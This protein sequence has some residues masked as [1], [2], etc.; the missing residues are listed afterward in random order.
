M[1]LMTLGIIVLVAMMVTLVLARIFLK[2]FFRVLSII[3]LVLFVAGAVFGLLVYADAMEMKEKM[4]SMPSIFLLEKDGSLRAGF[5]AMGEK[6]ELLE[7]P[8]DFQDAYSAK[9]YSLIVGDKYYKAFMFRFEAFNSTPEIKINEEISIPMSVVSKAFSSESPSGEINGYL[10]GQGNEEVDFSEFESSAEAKGV[11]FSILVTGLTAENPVF[12][13]KGIKDKNII[14]YEETITFK[15][16][17]YFPSF[18]FDKAMKIVSSM[19]ESEELK[20]KEEA[21]NEPS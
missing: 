1:E 4:A 9:D 14:V 15:A 20:T 7:S 21:S 5:S 16:L 11:I 13:I 3:W 17:R 12:L 19:A 2:T 6:P 8:S 10:S 18:I